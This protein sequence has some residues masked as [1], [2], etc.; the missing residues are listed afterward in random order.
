MAGLDHLAQH[1]PG[2]EHAHGLARDL[3]AVCVDQGLASTPTALLSSA[4][5]VLGEENPAPGSGAPIETFPMAFADL[6]TPPE[7]A[8]YCQRVGRSDR[9]AWGV[10]LLSLMGMIGALVMAWGAVLI[11]CAIGFVVSMWWAT[12]PPFG[13]SPTDTRQRRQMADYQR[14]LAA[15]DRA[16]LI[17]AVASPE[18]PTECRTEVRAFLN[19][20][21]RGWSLDPKS[22]PRLDG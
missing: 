3:A 13:P 11:G 8:A 1:T 19:T 15:F 20:H 4:Q 21:H 7:E 18:L 5:A 14:R 16:V 6:P 17:R 10:C 22:A 9:I 12:T 2:S